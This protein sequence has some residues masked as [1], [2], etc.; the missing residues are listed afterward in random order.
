MRI[1]V[2]LAAVCVAFPGAAAP[3]KHQADAKGS[4]SLPSFT[5]MGHSPSSIETNPTGPDGKPCSQNE[6]SVPGD[7]NCTEFEATLAG[8]NID[9]FISAD[10]YQ[11]RLYHLFGEGKE[12]HYGTIL[13]AFTAKYGAPKMSTEPWES[14][15]GAKFDNLIAT[16]KFRDGTLHLDQMGME[17]DD[18]SFE[19]YSSSNHPPAPTAKV[20]F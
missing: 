15:A 12:A 9:G 3:A 20:D 6:K 11:G 5:F 7:L 16:W 1:V 10:F 19:F 14:K 18:F 13:Q 17:R 2:L 8:E 4:S